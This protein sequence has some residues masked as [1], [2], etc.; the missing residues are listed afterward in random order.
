MVYFGKGGG[1]GGGGGSACKIL[2]TTNHTNAIIKMLQVRFQLLDYMR[3]LLS[4][5]FVNVKESHSLNVKELC[6]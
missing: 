2:N 1:G 3:A 4:L 6:L 5:H